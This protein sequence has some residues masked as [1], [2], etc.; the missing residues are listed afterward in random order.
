MCALAKKEP[1]EDTV[2]AEFLNQWIRKGGLVCRILD[3][4][5]T[6]DWPESDYE[7]APDSGYA[8]R[9]FVMLTVLTYCYATG[10]Y[11]SKE[12]ELKTSQDEILRF[13]CAGTQL[14]ERHIRDFRRQNRQRIKQ[15]L[16]QAGKLASDSRFEVERPFARSAEA[17]I[18]RAEDCD[19]RTFVR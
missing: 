1:A 18:R 14:T 5:Q 8:F 2:P 17:R 7:L 6:L 19:A 15:C 11:G 9:P 10:V 4:V 12:I 16:I 13:L 3:A